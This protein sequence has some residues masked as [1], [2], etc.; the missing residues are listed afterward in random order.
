MRTYIMTG[1]GRSGTSF[2]AECLKRNGVNIGHDFYM[3][4]NPN[5]GYENQELVDVTKKILMDAGGADGI[6][7]VPA[8]EDMMKASF[9]DNKHYIISFINNNKDESWG[10][11]E[12]RLSLMLDEYLDE[13]TAVDEDPFIYAAFRR[14]EKV[15]ESLVKLN[16]QI[17]YN[18]ALE[19]AKE[20][21]RRLL[22]SLAKF[23]GV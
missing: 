23:V 20:Y 12:P 19:A 14:P 2:L 21:N 22:K 4:E 6:H 17:D 9:I 8:S 5:H 7:A 1:M 11:K 3:G 15:A 10:V 18:E 16:N 13:I